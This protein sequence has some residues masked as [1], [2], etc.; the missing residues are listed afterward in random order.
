MYTSI[1]PAPGNVAANWSFRVFSLEL[2]GRTL[3]Y[4]RHTQLKHSRDDHVLFLRSTFV[5]S[6]WSSVFS[7]SANTANDLSLRRISIPDFI[8]HFFCPIPI[9]EKELLYFPIRA[10]IK[11][12]KLEG[13]QILEVPG[14]CFG[15][16]NFS[17]PNN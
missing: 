17:H 7:F 4:Y 6:A 16:P 9:L 14:K 10:S 8:H 15:S 11:E 5:C 13:L 2:S 3:K 12:N 1:L